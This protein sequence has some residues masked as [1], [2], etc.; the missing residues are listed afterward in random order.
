MSFRKRL[1]TALILLAVVFFC[2][3]FLPLVGF[4]LVLQVFILAPLFEFY[5][6]SIKGN[7]FPQKTIGIFLA[8]IIS[9]SFFFEEISLEPALFAAIVL[10]AVYFLISFNR[11]EKLRHFTASVAI[12]FFG[13]LYLSF[14]LNFFYPLRKE[15]G[16]FYIYFLLAIIFLGDTGA[17]F[18]GKLWG[19]RKQVPMASP[20]K[21]WEGSIGGIIFAL[22]GAIAAQQI[23]L[24]DVILWK[25]ALCGLLVHAVAQISDPVESLFKR[26]VGVKDSSNVLPG[27]GGFLDRIDSLILATPFFYYF[28]KYIWY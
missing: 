19:R 22:I 1:P 18:L 15:Y 8:L 28:V 6:L 16:P 24:R 9:M 20:R 17:Y 11:V 25:A 21:T 26:A 13:A 23:L 10:T 2:I 7:I 5:N 3:Q 14:T 12:T 27:H 4:F